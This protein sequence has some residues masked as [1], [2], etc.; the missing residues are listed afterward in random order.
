MI[1]PLKFIAGLL[2]IAVG[3]IAYV[4][5]VYKARMNKRTLNILPEIQYIPRKPREKPESLPAM[6][7]IA[8]TELSP[9]IEIPVIQPTQN[10]EEK[11][12]YQVDKTLARKKALA[13]IQAIRKSFPAD[14]LL[15]PIWDKND[16]WSKTE[17]MD[18]TGTIAFVN[19]SGGFWGILG[20]EGGQYQPIEGLPANYQIEGLKVVAKLIPTPA[21]TIFMW[22]TTVRIQSIR[23]LI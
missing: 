10:L 14:D 2:S 17:T 15:D 16:R 12:T 21:F 18:I 20:D 22:G 23:K 11:N 19:L 13:R 1:N 4:Y 5:V 7:A 6:E 3:I 9:E 8:E